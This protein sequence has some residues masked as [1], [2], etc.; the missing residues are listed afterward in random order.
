MKKTFLFVIPAKAGIQRVGVNVVRLDSC[1][2][3]SD[4]TH[5]IRLHLL[6][7][8]YNLMTGCVQFLWTIQRA[9]GVSP[10]VGNRAIAIRGLRYATGSLLRFLPFFPQPLV[11]FLRLLIDSVNELFESIQLVS[12][13][14][15]LRRFRFQ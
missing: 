11:E 10:P 3:R 5:C 15:Y 14:Q 9:A 8:Q 12:K 7:I 6:T 13:G 1:L 2:R 4:N